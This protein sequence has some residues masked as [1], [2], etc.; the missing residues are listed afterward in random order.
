MKGL[1]GRLLFPPRCAACGALL[2]WYKEG[3]GLCES[4]M[5]AW[6]REKR[7]ACAICAKDVCLCSC[8]PEMMKKAKCEGFRK[9]TYY[10][11]NTKKK[12]QN[13]VIYTIKEKRARTAFAFLA[14]EMKP[15]VDEIVGELPISDFCIVYLP[16]TTEAKR[17]HDLDQAEQLARALSK[18]TGILLVPAIDRLGGKEQKRLLP[19]ERLKNAQKSFLIKN[20]APLVGKHILLVDDLVTTGAGMAVATKLLRRAGAK[21]VYALTVAS[22]VIN[23]EIL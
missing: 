18:Q 4:C 9:L 7:E 22:D 20:E 17:K 13:R 23:R 15:L 1:I 14:S 2:D 10:Y 5:E 11:P 8:M 16:R 6:S 12:V 3:C 19:S 21:S